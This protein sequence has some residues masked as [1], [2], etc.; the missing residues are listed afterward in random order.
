[1]GRMYVAEFE[2]VAVTAAQDF[3]ELA[4]AA[5]RPIKIHAVFLANITDVGDAEEEMLRVKVIRGHTT[6]GSGGTTQ[7]PTALDQ[8]DAASG[9]TSAELNNTTIASAG[10]PVDLHSESFNIRTGWQWIP[11]PEMRPRCQN[12][13]LIV[14]RLMAAP[15]D[16]VTMSGTV[17]FEEV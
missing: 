8:N 17:Y 14:V 16:S 9:V 11:T 5:N 7:T 2:N 4:P 15:T 1:M 3:F 13:E 12:A 10:T 6:T